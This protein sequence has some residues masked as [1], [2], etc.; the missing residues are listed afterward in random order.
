M[1][2]DRDAATRRFREPDR[3]RDRWVEH[4]EAEP[5]LHVFEHLTRVTAAWVE[6]RR[7]HAAHPQSLVRE[8]AYVGD[9][10]EQLR[11]ASVAQGFALQRDDD[12]VGRGEA[13]D[14]EHAERR[15]AVDEHDVERIA[16]GVDRACERVLASGA[17]QEVDFRT[18]EIDVGREQAHA[19]RVDDRVF[20]LHALEQ[21]VVQRR[22]ALLGLEAEREGEARLRVEVDEEHPLAEVRQRQPDGLGRRGLGDAAFL[23]GD[24]EHPRHG[25]GVYERAF[26][27][28]WAAPRRPGV[29]APDLG[30]ATYRVRLCSFCDIADAM[31]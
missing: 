1:L 23:V 9:R 24:R 8:L 18:G 20:G 17:G 21:H 10:L 22:G 3:L 4:D 6:H 12:F 16:D 19:A 15:R 2:E 29:F 25:V 11:D 5:G 30:R 14:R 13:V 26:G 27:S 28:A 31:P 7:D